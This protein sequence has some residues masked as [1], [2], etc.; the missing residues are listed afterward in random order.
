MP[1][2][3]K[4][5]RSNDLQST[6]SLDGLLDV[7]A[8]QLPGGNTQFI[9]QPSFATPGTVDRSGI[10]NAIRGVGAARAEAASIAPGEFEKLQKETSLQLGSQLLFNAVGPDLLQA[11]TGTRSGSESSRVRQLMME[12]LGNLGL[13]RTEAEI[14]ARQA[15]IVAPAEAEAAIAEFDF[16][17]DSAEAAQLA[18]AT[19]KR[20]QSAQAN[21]DTLNAWFREQ[22][23][24]KRQVAKLAYEEIEGMV[25]DNATVES[26]TARAKEIYPSLTEKD[27]RQ[28]AAT[29][30]EVRA[31]KIAR[32]NQAG[33]GTVPSDLNPE[34]QYA[35]AY[36]D[37]IEFNARFIERQRQ[38]GNVLDLY[39]SAEEAIAG[40]YD[41]D[42]HGEVGSQS[43]LAF[44]EGISQYFTLKER[45]AGSAAVLNSYAS[46]SAGRMGV[47]NPFSSNP[48]GGGV[49]EPTPTSPLDFLGPAQGSAESGGESSPTSQEAGIGL[50][51]DNGRSFVLGQG[52][53]VS[54]RLPDG[55]SFT[56]QSTSTGQGGAVFEHAGKRY[57]IKKSED[58]A[59]LFYVDPDG[60]V[61][62]AVSDDVG[63]NQEK[64]EPE[65]LD[66]FL[67]QRDARQSQRVA[68]RQERE[69]L[70]QS[71]Q[72]YARN[73]VLDR[74]SSYESFKSELE[75]LRSE[76]GDEEEISDAKIAMELAEKEAKDAIASL[77]S[78]DWA[79][80]SALERT[81]AGVRFDH[82]VK[83]PS[84]KKRGRG[85]GK[86]LGSASLKNTGLG[87]NIDSI[88]NNTAGS[89]SIPLALR[90]L[91]EVNTLAAN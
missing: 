70:I 85:G 67:A 75:D 57:L 63:E 83:R 89:D 23:V 51:V 11:L 19:N 36:R 40:E 68:K 14:L 33:R 25:E 9:S 8:I 86:A 88:F 15:G 16:K 29:A 84:L 38:V 6:L 80:A 21:V 62:K 39:T 47:S 10:L 26:I 43:Y 72:D 34:V 74:I 5:R 28:M 91:L 69:D 87:D 18:E 13:R 31:S 56:E 41:P 53:L 54:I 44:S 58:G 76:D 7:E 66:E 48:F 52:G 42:R 46:D 59:E 17:Q 64:K 4:R 20:I 30:S 78:D 55:T 82:K 37:F 2:R 81:G 45:T 60:S 22:P 32:N 35:K 61:K 77:L 73:V 71:Y 12:R 24:E 49:E 1:D 65:T 50:G 90:Q 79:L 3:D 27:I